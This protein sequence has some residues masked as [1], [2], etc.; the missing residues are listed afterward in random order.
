MQ[1]LANAVVPFEG[2]F[3]QFDKVL[4]RSQI[5]V[6]DFLGNVFGMVGHCLARLRPHPTQLRVKTNQTRTVGLIVL[7][8][9][10]VTFGGF[11]KGPAGGVFS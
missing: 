8:R 3:T 11:C 1:A 2:Y 5:G 6:Q 4:V 9:V 7:E 10:D